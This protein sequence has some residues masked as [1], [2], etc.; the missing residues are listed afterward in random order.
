M[1]ILNYI[2]FK[3]GSTCTGIYRS[4]WQCTRMC[5]PRDDSES[6]VNVIVFRLFLI[7]HSAGAHL[8][9]M[10]L[11]SEWNDCDIL[12]RDRLNGKMSWSTSP[13]PFF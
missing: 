12:T 13:Y 3:K 5:R 1:A 4:L 2:Y 6:Y 9:A 8:C 10:M 7:G 11:S